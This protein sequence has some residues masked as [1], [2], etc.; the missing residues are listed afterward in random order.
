MERRPCIGQP[1]CPSSREIL[2]AGRAWR[3]T[4]QRATALRAKTRRA[5]SASIH[6]ALLSAVNPM[7]GSV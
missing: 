7:S 6:W 1:R 2:F 5:P 4:V 3:G